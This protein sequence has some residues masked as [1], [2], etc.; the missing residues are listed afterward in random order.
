MPF[1]CERLELPEVILLG[2]QAFGDCR[3]FFLESYKRSLFEKCGI[4]QVFVQDNQSRS[5]RG[6]LRGLHYQKPP[7][8][9]AKLISVVRGEVFDVA[10]DIRRGSPSYGRWVG[11]EL[12]DQNH[13][14]LFVP[15]GFAH[16]FVV[17]SEEAD[18][19]YKVSREYSPE[20]ER[21]I[22]WNDPALGI[23]WPIQSPVLS[24]RDASL[25]R[26]AEADN[27]FEYAR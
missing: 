21:G 15:E 6:V 16:G 12:S 17:L 3:G 7:A 10:V 13:R 22:L 11:A 4:A 26:L 27:N 8:A 5:T 24:P 14:L 18:V 20:H 1:S 19:M 2:A 9:Q 25:P 23:E